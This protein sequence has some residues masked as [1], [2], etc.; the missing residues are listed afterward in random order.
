MGTGKRAVAGPST[1]R[2][3]FF[4]KSLE[5]K[6]RLGS[7]KKGNVLAETSIKER[8]PDKRPDAQRAP[9]NLVPAIVVSLAVLAN[10]C[11]ASPNALSYFQFAERNLH[12]AEPVP[13]TADYSS[14]LETLKDIQ[15]SQ[16]QNAAV[17]DSLTQRSANQLAAVAGIADQLSS[18]AARTVTSQITT[19]PETTSA[20]PQPSAPAVRVVRTTRK[21]RA[22]KPPGPFSIGEAR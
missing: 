15:L 13:T 7:R 2:L 9:S 3:V 8:Q 12:E 1:R 11:V 16:R 10:I 18:L 4:C 21:K 14:I 19:M 20:I 5:V 17:L 22:P 6:T